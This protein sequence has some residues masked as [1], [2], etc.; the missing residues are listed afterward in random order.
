MTSACSS[1]SVHKPDTRLC[2]T[3]KGQF[4]EC[5]D[6][7]LSEKNQILSDVSDAYN[8]K[9]HFVGLNEYT[10][11]MAMGLKDDLYNKKLK[12]D[13]AVAS[14]VSRDDSLRTSNPLGNELAEY[15]IN[16]LA[17]LGLPV[18]DINVT[19]TIDV[20]PAGSFAFSRSQNDV[21]RNTNIAYVLTGTMLRTS[22]GVMVNARLI[23]LKSKQVVASSGKLFPPMLVNDLH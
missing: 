17:N 13:I 1:F 2:A 22:S 10:Q 18:S 19:G 23:E 8:P 4:Y 21:I 3:E 20:E 6:L 14:F 5:Q 7:L 9:R 15:F 11:Q 12:G 16:D